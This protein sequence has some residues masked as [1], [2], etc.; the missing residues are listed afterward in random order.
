L[1]QSSRTAFV[2]TAL[3]CAGHLVRTASVSINV[4]AGGDLQA[5]I[6]RAQPG[7]VILLEAG[8]T[9]VGNFILPA[10]PG[11]EYITIRSAADPSSFPAGRVAPEHARWMP[12]LQSPSG[13]PALATAPGAHHWRLRWLAFR[14]NPIGAND[15]ITLGDGSAAQRDASA[16]PHHLVLDGVIIR[17][18]PDRGAKRGIALNSAS[19]TIRNS[20]IRGIKAVGQDSQAICGWNGPGPFVI[21]DNYLEG[22]GENVMFGGADPAI[23]DLVPSDITFRHNYVTKPLEWRDSQWTVKNLFELKNARRVLV[24]W[25]VFENNWLAAQTGYAILFTPLN[26]DATAPWTVVSD[27]TFQYNV[28]RHVSSAFNILGTDYHAPSQQTR[29]I[30]IRQNLLFDVDAA[31]WGGDGRFVLIGDEPTDLVIDHNTVL[32]TG[33]FLQLYGTR[34]D[35]RPRV[36]T[37]IHV[38]NN[39]A[40]HNEYGI[41]GDGY[42]TGMPAITAYMTREEVRR[43][44]LAGGDASRYPPDNYFPAVGE[45]LSEFVDSANSDF[46]LRPGSRYRTAGT[47]GTKLGA[48]VEVLRRGVPPGDPSG[49]II[50]RR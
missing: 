19:T 25:N 42:A 29:G 43:N 5:A 30:A 4:P 21:E 16:V 47:D 13:A 17:G 9:Y 24:E 37:N 18:D 44:V 12:T 35:G 14:A 49:S 26:Q 2:L 11:A 41:I 45:F 32:G 15:I 10:K 38:T 40:R 23:P 7:D 46:R 27:V 22:A 50:R 1:S 28:V 20:D 36:I 33:S 6:D 3:L 31:R 48:D 39:L 34:D 8:A